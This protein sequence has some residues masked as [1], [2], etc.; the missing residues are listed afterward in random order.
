MTSPGTYQTFHPSD[1]RTFH[2]NARKGNVP[3]IAASLR[4]NGQFVPIVVNLGTHTGRPNEVLKGNHTLKAFRYL[5]EKYPEDERWQTI[6]AVVWDLDD[7]QATRINIAD[8]RTS[9]LGTND[10]RLLLEQLSTLEH[11]EGTGYDQDDFDALADL[12]ANEGDL[13]QFP[14]LEGKPADPTVEPRVKEVVCPNCDHLF[15]VTE[16]KELPKSAAEANDK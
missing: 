11:F 10:D 13:D 7:D 1:L 14:E 6:E 15:P 16:S 5:G 8:N 3:A 9:E 4:S 12:V 2:S